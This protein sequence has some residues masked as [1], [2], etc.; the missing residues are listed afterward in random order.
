MTST[1]REIVGGGSRAGR[2]RAGD[3]RA[4]SVVGRVRRLIGEGLIRNS[5]FLSTNLGIGAVTGLGTLTLLTHL[6]SVR[7]VGLSAAALSASGLIVTISQLGLNYSLVRFLP[8]SPHRRDLINSALTA[9]MLV[10]LLAGGIF[11]LL[12]SSHKLYALGRLTFAGTFLLVTSLSAGAALIMNVFVADRAVGATVRPTLIVSAA[13]LAAPAALVF[14]GLVGAYLAQGVVPVGVDFLVVA[15]LLARRGHRFRPKL[16]S[17]A[18]R[19]L[20]KFS[21]GAYIAGLIGG[22]PAIVVPLI[23]LSRFGPN[24]NAY[25]YTAMAGGT[26]LFGI[27]SAVSQ[28]L[29]AETAHQPAQRRALVRKAALVIAAVMLPVLTIAYLAAPFGLALLGHHYAADGLATLRLLIVAAGMSSVNYIGGTILYLAKKTF[30][31]AVINTVDAIVVLGLAVTWAQGAHG[32]AVA[33]VIGEIGN[34][35]LFALFAAIAVY[36]VHG[37]WE[38]LGG[39]QP[40]P[41]VAALLYGTAESQQ[42][43]L[44]LLLSLSTQGLTG[45]IYPPGLPPPAWLQSDTRRRTRARHQGSAEERR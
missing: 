37:R 7:A 40:D 35:I 19:E 13:R 24:Q 23:I 18:T 26:V 28:A 5:A 44:D 10:A 45:P 3:G 42:A 27:P 4:H 36:Q 29:L 33:W 31:I 14:T 1:G 20:R 17:A 39:D 9:T 2:H 8:K 6:Y 43:G 15:L 41:A 25:W 12:P 16:S 30:I 22:L 32:I 34:V 38:A 21:V 11:L